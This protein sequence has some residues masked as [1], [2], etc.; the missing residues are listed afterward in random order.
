MNNNKTTVSIDGKYVNNFEQVTLKQA[1]NEHHNFTVVIKHDELEALGSHTLDASKAVLGKPIVIAFGEMEFLGIITNVKLVHSGGHHQGNLELSGF[2]KTILLDAGRHTRSWT[3]KGLAAMVKEVTGEAELEAEVNPRYKPLLPYATQYNES[4]FTFLKR[5]SKQYSEW[6][7]YDGIKLVFGKPIISNSTPLEYGSDLDR[8]SMGIRAGASN[9]STFSYDAM[10][11]T[12]N[13]A[14]TKNEVEGLNE[15][16]MGALNTSMGLFPNMPTSHS[17][18][19]VQD[20]R[21]LEASLQGRQAAA[22]AD[23]NVLEARCSRQGL[24]VGSIVKVRSAR[25]D[26]KNIF[27]EQSYGEYLII[28]IAHKAEGN[29]VYESHFKAIPAGVAVLPAPEVDMPQ[30]HAQTATVV[31]NEDPKGKGRVKVQFGWQKH[32][33]GTNWLRVLMPDAGSSDHRA[34][35]RGHVFVPEVGDQVMVGFRYGDPNRPFVMG[36]V[37]NGVNGAGGGPNNAIKSITTRSGHRLEFNDTQGSERITITDR[38]KNTILL[39]TAG[40]SIRISAPENISISAKN[41]DITASESLTASAGEGIGINAGEDITV[42][43]GKGTTLTANTNL[44]IISKDVSV[45]A[46]EN[47]EAVSKGMEEHSE[48]SQK[49]TTKGDIKINSAKEIKSNTGNTVKL[50]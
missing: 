49:S 7:Y 41:I 2:S 27:N 42:G 29:S 10:T 1:I 46:C 24:T 22:L 18:T 31:A 40:S 26:G 34:Q 13:E 44:N 19:S 17:L 36:G 47:F 45:Q 8:I 28:E 5:L 16:A 11:D 30:A 37:F 6:L 20:K 43:A 39:D 48:T 33:M 14:K 50:H 23:L 35:N 21:E 25:W 9:Q 32:Q 15:L 3:D 38:N 4:G 12:W